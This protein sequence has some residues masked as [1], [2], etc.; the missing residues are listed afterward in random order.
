MEIDFVQVARRCI[1]DDEVEI[2]SVAREKD[3]R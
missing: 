1:G 3:G 2:K